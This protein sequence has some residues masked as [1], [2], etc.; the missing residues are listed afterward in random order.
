[1]DKVVNIMTKVMQAMTLVTA[2]MTQVTA[3]LTRVK[4]RIPLKDAKLLVLKTL[5][6]LVG[7]NINNMCLQ[8]LLMYIHTHA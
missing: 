6:S 1:M 7:V 2:G 5:C 4:P 8:S 3:C